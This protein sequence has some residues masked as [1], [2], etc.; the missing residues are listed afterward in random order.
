ML[1][2]ARPLAVRRSRKSCESW[3]LISQS[4][5]HSQKSPCHKSHA[6]VESASEEEPSSCARISRNVPIN[7]SRETWLFLN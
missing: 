7:S 4:A 2:G 6:A 3:L 5:S 1:Q